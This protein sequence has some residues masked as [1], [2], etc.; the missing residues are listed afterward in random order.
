MAGAS[1]ERFAPHFAPRADSWGRAHCES[2]AI[3]PWPEPGRWIRE[4]NFTASELLGLDRGR[5]LGRSLA[6]DFNNGLQAI[7]GRVNVALAGAT[8]PERARQYLERAARAAKSGGELAAQ[9]MRFSRQ[10]DTDGQ[11]IELDTV[12]RNARALIERLVTEAISVS[13]EH[14]AQGATI[15]ADAV[16]IEQILMNLASNARDA[17]PDG[18]HLRIRTH[19]ATTA[20]RSI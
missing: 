13:I 18:G 1:A 8:P 10:R 17:M 4:A 9:L 2:R 3:L 7:L 5:L 15:V 11:P 16:E 14:D 19:L 20:S 6:H 12:V